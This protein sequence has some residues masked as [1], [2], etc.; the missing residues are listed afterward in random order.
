M[1][2][3]DLVSFV[4]ASEIRFKILVSLNN[5]VQ[6][7]TDLKREFNVPIS[8]ISAV[9]KELSEK[10]LIENLTPERRKSKMYSITEEGRKVLGE[11]HHLTESGDSK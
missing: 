10:E 11:I 9:L 2:E 1:A 7:P 4:I 5:K 8:R 6:T 3:W